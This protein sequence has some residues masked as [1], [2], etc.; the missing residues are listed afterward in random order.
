MNSSFF[1]DSVN[2]IL[3]FLT[4]LLSYPAF[5]KFRVLDIF[6][7]VGVRDMDIPICH[8]KQRRVTELIGSL[9]GVLNV[10]VLRPRLATV[11]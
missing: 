11:T 3:E 10:P 2:V 5:D 4:W 7:Y 1:I 9:A 8:L 6:P